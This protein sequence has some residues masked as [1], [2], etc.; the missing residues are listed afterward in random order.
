MVGRIGESGQRN[1][2][3]LD[4]N[5][6]YGLSL[7]P[8]YRTRRLPAGERDIENFAGGCIGEL[9]APGHDVAGH[10]EA[11]VADRAGKPHVR[12]RL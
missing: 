12:W 8:A 4:P 7:L 1:T 2:A 9:N 3:L 5:Y 11:G 6:F 10:R